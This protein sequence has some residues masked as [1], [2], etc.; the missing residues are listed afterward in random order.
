MTALATARVVTAVA[1]M[2]TAVTGDVFGDGDAPAPVTQPTGSTT[3]RPW[4]VVDGVPGGARDDGDVADPASGGTVVIQVTCVGQGVHARKQAAWLS[5]RAH[6]AILAVSATGGWLNP[7]P[8]APTVVVGRF[9]LDDG[10][11][12]REGDV[13]NVYEQYRLIVA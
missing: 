8:V 5:D 10:G 9:H 7:I 4:G 13:V 6:Q 1:E 3:L 11:S 12:D 2:L